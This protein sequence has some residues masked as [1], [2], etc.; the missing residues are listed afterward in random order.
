VLVCGYIVDDPATISVPAGMQEVANLTVRG[1]DT[2]AV[3]FE[4]LGP[5]PETGARVARVGEA[6][7]GSDD[8]S[9]AI[10]LRPGR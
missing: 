4:E 2:W 1:D 5:H 8:F 3:A 9:Q 6:E 10:V 7:G